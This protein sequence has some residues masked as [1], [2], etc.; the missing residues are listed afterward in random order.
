MIVSI[1]DY[2]T[3]GYAIY[4]RAKASP[5][6]RLRYALAYDPRLCRA[7]LGFVRALLAFE[8]RRERAGASS[9]AAVP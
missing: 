3:G 9:G 7:V 2:A 1:R 4:A 8:R 6:R 5:E